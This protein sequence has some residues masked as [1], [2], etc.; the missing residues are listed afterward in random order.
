MCTGRSPSSKG[1]LMSSRTVWHAYALSSQTLGAGQGRWNLERRNSALFSFGFI[2][3]I[4]LLVFSDGGYPCLLETAT[5][6]S[7]GHAYQGVLNH[8][9]ALHIQVTL[10]IYQFQFTVY[11]S[12]DIVLLVVPEACSRSPPPPFFSSLSLS[13]CVIHPSS[14]SNSI[15]PRV[16]SI[17]LSSFKT[18]T[19]FHNGP[20]RSA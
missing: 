16:S 4:S 20:L 14:L 9:Q 3:W 19:D 15:P 12:S 11:C 10:I 8:T 1:R 18:D 5:S 7:F 13:L 6:F 2:L 17:L